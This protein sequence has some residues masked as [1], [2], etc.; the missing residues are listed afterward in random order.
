VFQFDLHQRR[1]SRDAESCDLALQKPVGDIHMQTAL[2]PARATLSAVRVSSTQTDFDAVCGVLQPDIVQSAPHAWAIL[3]DIARMTGKVERA[4]ELIGLAYLAYDMRGPREWD[5]PIDF[6]D[7]GEPSD[8]S[9]DR[10]SVF[11]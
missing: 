5:T 8:I 10:L 11:S 6:E 7:E 2:V 4:E 3:A 1:A 9:V